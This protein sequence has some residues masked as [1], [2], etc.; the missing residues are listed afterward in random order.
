MNSL[1]KVVFSRT[2][3]SAAWNNT[4]LFSG[5]LATEVRALKAETGPDMVIMGSGGI[6]AHLTSVGL[7]DEYQI[8]ISPIALG[9]GR[10]L[11]EG[12]K[13]RAPMKLAKSRV[14]GNGNA[15]LFYQPSA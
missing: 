3:G 8:V 1:P 15:V 14:F 4:R 5:D 6:V 2:M 7:I 9:A 13:T 11:F 12:L 10:T